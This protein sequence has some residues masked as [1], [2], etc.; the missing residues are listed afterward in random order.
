[1][2]GQ[3]LCWNDSEGFCGLCGCNLVPPTLQAVRASVCGYG[4]LNS[5]LACHSPERVQARDGCCNAGKQSKPWWEAQDAFRGCAPSKRLQAELLVLPPSIGSYLLAHSVGRNAGDQ[6][7]DLFS[8]PYLLPYP[9]SSSV[10]DNVHKSLHSQHCRWLFAQQPA[11]E[12]THL[13]TSLHT[14]HHMQ[15]YQSRADSYQPGQRHW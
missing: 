6:P 1:M 15:P 13:D 5:N 9:V 7:Q 3:N 14:C 2:Q 12:P 10:D 4:C 8:A 11:F